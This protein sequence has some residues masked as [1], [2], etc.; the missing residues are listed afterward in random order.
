MTPRQKRL[1][2]IVGGVAVL[3]VAAGL[4]LSALNS[5]IVFFYTPSEIARGEAPKE[6]N[7]RIGGLVAPGSVQREGTRVSFVVTDNDPALAER[8]AIR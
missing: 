1:A 4:V 3:A 2:W 6:R 5:N 8:E 7:F